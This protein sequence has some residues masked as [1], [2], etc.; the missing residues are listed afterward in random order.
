M[1][2]AVKGNRETKI[3]ENE[4]EKYIEQGHKIIEIEDGEQTIVYD[5]SKKV[6][7]S[8]LTEKIEKLTEE[9]E[10]FKIETLDK[11]KE[12]AT[13]FGVEYAPNIGLDTLITKIKEAKEVEV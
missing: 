10:V 13:H 7:E 1:L 12:L 11:V 9:L 8:A 5:P 2:V 6:D 3:D 4:K